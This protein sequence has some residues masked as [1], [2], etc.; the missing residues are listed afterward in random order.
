MRMLFQLYTL[1]NSLYHRFL[2][3]RQQM[4]WH[5][6]LFLAQGPHLDT[7]SRRQYQTPEAPRR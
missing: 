3:I 1:R 7:Y 5:P 6:E 2:S 4:L